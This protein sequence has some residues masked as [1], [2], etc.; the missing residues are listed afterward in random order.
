MQVGN[1]WAE[2]VVDRDKEED[3]RLGHTD[4]GRVHPELGRRDITG[5]NEVVG[6]EQE[7]REER[8]RRPRG[9]ISKQL[10]DLAGI[11]PS[12]SESSRLPFP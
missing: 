12:P 8:R 3:Q 6:P 9:S 4:S 10:A 7:L 2:H 1:E 5:K 11:G